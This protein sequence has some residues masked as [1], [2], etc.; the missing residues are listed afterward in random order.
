MRYGEFDSE[1]F[2]IIEQFY[3]QVVGSNQCLECT[4][5]CMVF[6]TDCMQK[7]WKIKTKDVS[8][9]NLGVINIDL[10]HCLKDSCLDIVSFGVELQSD[11]IDRR[12]CEG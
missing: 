6:T 8:N 3:I 1:N 9:I 5:Q 7:K 4:L 2:K 12:V 11:S 10:F